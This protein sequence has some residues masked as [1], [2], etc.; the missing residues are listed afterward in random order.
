MIDHISTDNILMK[1]YFLITW[2][3]LFFNLTG[4]V[5]FSHAIF[6]DLHAMLPLCT[7]LAIMEVLP[8]IYRT[9]LWR[10]HILSPNSFIF[11]K[12]SLFPCISSPYELMVHPLSCIT[13]GF[14]HLAFTF[15]VKIFSPRL[16]SANKNFI[17][18]FHVSYW[19]Q[20]LI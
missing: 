11:H 15:Y 16:S 17:Q 18:G 20:H 10:C 1:Y 2:P 14:L 4:K 8:P 7:L 13:Y 19:T 9:D 6:D 12:P 5:N 3:I